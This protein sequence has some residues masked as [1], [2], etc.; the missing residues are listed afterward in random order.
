M[1]TYRY[2]VRAKVAVALDTDGKGN[3]SLAVAVC[4]PVDQYSRTTARFILDTMLD[5]TPETLRA[6]NLRRNVFQFTYEGETP[7]RDVIKPLM[8][9]LAT[10]LQARIEAFEGKSDI[11][12]KNRANAVISEVSS[13]ALTR[14]RR[15]RPPVEAT[16]SQ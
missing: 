4:N 3:A 6:L 11:T 10:P 16:A 1:R 13:F 9:Q 7:V 15:E 5:Q 8:E 12:W 14:R 2:L